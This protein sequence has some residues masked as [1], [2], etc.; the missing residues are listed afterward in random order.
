MEILD[1]IFV[2]WYLF[3]GLGCERLEHT[4]TDHSPKMR[5]LLCV[6]CWPLFLPI[7]FFAVDND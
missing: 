7:V 4:R 2:V 3:V 1:I 5:R 6:G